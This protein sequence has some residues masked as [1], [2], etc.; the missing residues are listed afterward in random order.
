MGS[1]PGLCLTRKFSIALTSRNSKGVEA[2]HEKAR[3][4]T[5]HCQKETEGTHTPI[6]KVGYSFFVGFL[7]FVFCV[8]LKEGLGKMPPPLE[9]RKSCL[10]NW[11]GLSVNTETGDESE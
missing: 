8:F 10:E 3:V 6:I 11:R 7:F 4:A 1:C 5:R 2:T 9:I